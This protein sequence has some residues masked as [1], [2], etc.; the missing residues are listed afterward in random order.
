MCQK[1]YH[2]ACT[3]IFMGLH[4]MIHEATQFIW[5]TYQFS[6]QEDIPL[7]DIEGYRNHICIW[8]IKQLW[9]QIFKHHERGNT[10]FL[11][12]LAISFLIFLYYR[13]R[14]AWLALSSILAFDWCLYSQ[15][16]HIQGTLDTILCIVFYAFLAFWKLRNLDSSPAM[17]KDQY[18]S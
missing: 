3:I 14:E 13:R 2:L 15:N 11:E 7:L 8:I 4:S 18:H 12:L 17:W 1:L 6:T 9:F 10:C 16:H 5:Y